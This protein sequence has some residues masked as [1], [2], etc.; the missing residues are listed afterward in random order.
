MTVA[1]RPGQAPPRVGHVN[2]RGLVTHVGQLDPGV[3]A[4][5]EYGHDLVPRQREHTPDTAGHQLGYDTIR[6]TRLHL[7]RHLLSSSSG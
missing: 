6:T 7:L 3:D 5:I 1:R 4:R 2:G